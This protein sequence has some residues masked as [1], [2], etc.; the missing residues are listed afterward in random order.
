MLLMAE[1]HRRKRKKI[2]FFGDSIT[3]FGARP[4]GYI[5]YITRILKAADIEYNYELAGSGMD[6]D[7]VLD[8]Y[9][10]VDKDILSEGADVVVIL[11][12]VND[13]FNVLSSG[14]NKLETYTEIYEAL[15]KK[16]NDAVIKI[17]LCTP[18]VIGERI[19]LSNE[20]DAELNRYSDMV[21]RL[22]GKYDLP[23][24]DLRQ[25]FLNHNLV[26]NV[27]N[28]ESGILTFDSVHLNH[29][30]NQL[31]GEEIWKILQHV[32]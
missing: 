1:N 5:T 10:R 15:I 25:A 28:E 16:L 20:Y 8:L 4:G 30:G 18:T 12:G 19:D 13:V 3:N 29:R 7:T 11:I 26:N 9:K 32:K 17:V 14:E 21:R 24:V 27:Q 23:L 2:V 31:V 22:A 6:G